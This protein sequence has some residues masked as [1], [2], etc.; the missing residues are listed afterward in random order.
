MSWPTRVSIECT[1]HMLV[2]MG[3]VSLVVGYQ[4]KLDFFPLLQW[5]VRE[6]SWVRTRGSLSRAGGCAKNLSSQEKWIG[7]N[8]LM[9]VR[10]VDICGSREI[11]MVLDHTRT[12]REKRVVCWSD[13]PLHGVHRF[14]SS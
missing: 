2:F 10:K 14:K 13:F 8:M 4:H 9:T 3:S 1:D 11:R 7:S 12:E 6:R 5:L